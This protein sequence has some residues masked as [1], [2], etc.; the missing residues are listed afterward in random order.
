[1]KIFIGFRK[2]V[3][4]LLVLAISVTLLYY[5]YITGSDFA[6]IVSGVGVAFMG[7]N[8]G[9]RALDSISKYLEQKGD[10]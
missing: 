3:F 8:L 6:Q 1:M 10:K 2:F 9:E 5:N 4:A 7:A